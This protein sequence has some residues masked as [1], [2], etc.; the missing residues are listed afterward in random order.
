[1]GLRRTAY[2]PKSELQRTH[3]GETQLAEFYDDCDERSGTV[4]RRGFPYRLNNYR[5]VKE[6]FVPRS[7]LLQRDETYRYVLLRNFGFQG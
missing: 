5:L 6:D 3:Q 1:M 7:W 4:T 2:I